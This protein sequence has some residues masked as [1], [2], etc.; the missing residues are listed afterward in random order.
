M[1]SLFVIFFDISFAVS[2]EV[3]RVSSNVNIPFADPKVVSA[4]FG[5]F[6]TKASIFSLYLVL[7]PDCEAKCIVGVQNP[8]T[9]MQSQTILLM[10]IKFFLSSEIFAIWADLTFL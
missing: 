3:F 4:C 9:Q 7:F 5:L 2:N 8:E 6:G 10:L 1:F